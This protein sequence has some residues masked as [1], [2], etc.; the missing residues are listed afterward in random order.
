[1]TR[2]NAIAAVLVALIRVTVATVATAQEAAARPNVAIADVAVSPGGWTLPP[3]QMGETI[4][5]LLVGELVGSERFHVYDGQWLVPHQEA[6]GHVDVA[7]L[8]AAAADRRLDYVVLGTVTAFSMVQ[9][10][11]HAGGVLPLPSAGAVSGISINR[12]QLAVAVS[13]RIV[14]VRTGEIVTT[15]W[16]QGTGSRKSGGAALL[17]LLRCLPLPFALAGAHTVTNARDKMLDEALHQA[18]HNAALALASRQLPI[19]SNQ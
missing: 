12:S 8:R 14:D 18:V 11:N 9:S 2:R 15:A 19:T 5:E 17:G 6:G 3:P 10:R 4:V 16:G 7:H 13:F 1:M